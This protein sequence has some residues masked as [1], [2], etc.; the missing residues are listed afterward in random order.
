MTPDIDPTRGSDESVVHASDEAAA[1]IERLTAE[2]DEAIQA[3]KRSLADF[4]NY[5]RRAGEAE[6]RARD[7]GVIYAARMLMPVLD[8]IDMSLMQD[9]S[10]VTVEHLLQ[11]KSMIKGELNKSLEKLGI[12]RIEPKP[13]DEFD[14]HSQEAVMRQALPGVAANHVAMC[15]QVGYRLGEMTLRPAKV[16]VTPE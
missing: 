14:P 3:Y 6:I 4:A 11:A 13:G 16:S 10:K 7:S 2:R 1:L 8:Q 5:Q 15:L 12:D 9:A